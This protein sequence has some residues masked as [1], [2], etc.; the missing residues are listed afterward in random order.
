MNKRVCSVKPKTGILES[1][2]N[3][4]LVFLL[5]SSCSSEQEEKAAKNEPFID[6]I[7]VVKQG[8]LNL[9][10]ATGDDFTFGKLKNQFAVDQNASRFAFWD[11]T[12]KQILLTS[13]NGEIIVQNGGSG[14]G[15]E[16]FQQVNKFGFGAEGKLYVLDN[17]MR[18]LNTYDQNLEYQESKRLSFS[19]N[20][21]YPHGSGMVIQN[22]RL[23]VPILEQEYASPENWW[24]ST[25]IAR[26][27]PVN[28]DV[29]NT[30]GQYDSLLTD[31]KV[32][33]NTPIVGIDSEN[34]YL[35]STHQSLN[36]IQV[37]NLENGE[38]VTHISADR[39]TNFNQPESE[40]SPDRD[41]SET[42]KESIGL[43]FT[44]GVY[45]T[46]DYI[47]LYYGNLT[48]QFVKTQNVMDRNYFVS[49][50]DK[51]DYSYIGDKKLQYPLG[52]VD[53]GKLY[54]IENKNPNDY[55]IGIYKFNKK[56]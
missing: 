5:I 13:R 34:G 18:K 15:P 20:D 33:W 41:H 25:L 7:S 10:N 17:S 45:A 36:E 26:I 50:F 31:S 29:S 32:Y 37:F 8:E 14:R 23:L 28:G 9:H 52:A 44:R 6:K 35:L 30:F 43:S 11:A 21:M 3:L 47:I 27:D 53:D 16:E 24:Q 40:I 56:N 54:L 48:E 39:S 42:I 4:L 46:D 55:T 49:L 38:R 12:K 22:E 1:C 19:A 51:A 2:F